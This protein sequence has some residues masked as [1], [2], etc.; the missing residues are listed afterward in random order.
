MPVYSDAYPQL[1]AACHFGAGNASLSPTTAPGMQDSVTVISF[2]MRPS[3]RFCFTAYLQ[4]RD[5]FD[6]HTGCCEAFQ[7][8]AGGLKSCIPGAFTDRVVK[9]K[10]VP[11]SSSPRLQEC[12]AEAWELPGKNS[13]RSVFHKKKLFK[14]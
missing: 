4:P 2:P 6:F 11:L 9:N 8:S 5:V 7:E 14:L 12:C 1:R 3:G 10:N 13:R